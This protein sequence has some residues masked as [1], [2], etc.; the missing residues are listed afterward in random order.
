MALV[1]LL[2]PVLQ[3]ARAQAPAFPTVPEG[4]ERDAGLRERL[5][6]REASRT[7]SLSFPL[8]GGYHAINVTGEYVSMATVPKLYEKQLGILPEWK[9][10]AVP[11]TVSYSYSLP[12][13]GGRLIPVA[14][15]G[16]AAYLYQETNRQTFQVQSPISIEPAGPM[17]VR[18]S[19]Q[20]GQ[21]APAPPRGQVV[22]ET[23]T[24]YHSRHS[25]GITYGGE[26]F[27]GVRTLVLDNLYVQTLWRYRYLRSYADHRNGG[28]RAYVENRP[29]SDFDLSVGIGF[30]F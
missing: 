12:A 6:V 21:G 25:F 7:V 16:V 22:S 10:R 19:A 15:A 2:L 28:P 5:S 9:F 17:P 14:G 23:S 3:S 27:V 8:A 13:L 29:Y 26:A 11:V 1:C 4:I 20:V 30:I 24:T 18:F